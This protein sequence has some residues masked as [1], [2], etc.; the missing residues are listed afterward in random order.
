MFRKYHRTIMHHKLKMVYP[1]LKSSLTLLIS[2]HLLFTKTHGG[3]LL[4]VPSGSQKVILRKHTAVI[5]FQKEVCFILWLMS[6]IRPTA[7]YKKVPDKPPTH[8]TLQHIWMRGLRNKND[9]YVRWESNLPQT[10]RPC[11]VIQ[12]EDKTGGSFSLT[13][14][15]VSQRCRQTNHTIGKPLQTISERKSRWLLEGWVR[16]DEWEIA[17]ASEHTDRW[18]RTGADL[19][20]RPSWHQ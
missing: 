20:P 13:T 7:T 17:H 12:L 9:F 4:L 8:N 11:A 3:K 2:Q 1:L 10:R 6:N 18:R 15:R 14:N 16:A 5:M 19:K